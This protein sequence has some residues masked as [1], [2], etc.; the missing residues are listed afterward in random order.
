MDFSYG[1]RVKKSS[2]AF[3]TAFFAP[4]TTRVTAVREF[5]LRGTE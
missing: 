5:W 2:E 4:A 3:R 1:F